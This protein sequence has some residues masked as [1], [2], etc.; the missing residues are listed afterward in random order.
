MKYVL[1][2]I[3]SGYWEEEDKVPDATLR[4]TNKAKWGLIWNTARA[5]LWQIPYIPEGGIPENGNCP[6]CGEHDSGVHILGRC[7]HPE[8]K[9]MHIHRHDEAARTIINAINKGNHGSFLTI[10]DVGSAATLADLGVHHKR[11]PTWVLP[12]SELNMP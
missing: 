1:Q 8:M 5:W 2:E 4:N 10:A 11:I 3:S 12:D 6:L 9:K 7:S